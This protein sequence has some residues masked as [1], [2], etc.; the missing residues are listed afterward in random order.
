MLNVAANASNEYSQQAQAVPSVWVLLGEGAG[1]NAQMLQ[2]AQ[3]LGWPYEAK[4]MRYNQ[5]NHLPN[6]LL[7]G[8]II[9]VDEAKSAALS[10]PWPDVVIAASRRSAPVARWIKKQSGGRS[11]LVHLLHTQAPLHYFDLVVTLP[12]YRLPKRDNVLHNTLPLN[13]LDPEKLEHA[14][15]RWAPKYQ[16]LPRPWIGVLVGGDSSSYRLDDA[17][18]ARL[19]QIASQ[20]AHAAGASLLVTT[21]PRTP[22]V[23][24]KALQE[25]I[26]CPASIYQWQPDD[27][28]NPYLG[29]LALANRFIVTAD[30]ASLPAEAC[31]TGKPVQ[32]FDWQPR[33][34]SPSKSTNKLVQRV[35]A[36]LVYWGLIKPRRDFAA[37]HRALK[38]Q[39]LIG[40]EAALAAP[41]NDLATTVARIRALFPA[42]PAR[43]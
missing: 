9:S 6:P 29:I 35:H 31:A 3:A 2:L 18:A 42:S 28:D 16:H 33:A 13:T 24:I 27:A 19:G 11:K 22:A 1:G 38:A 14:A 39:G 43:R 7:G 4:Q 5:L 37:F 12:Q 26:T 36:A 17:T 30:S 20:A 32:L 15:Q 8:S 40:G 10:P 21:S 34:S 25:A 23:A 41:P